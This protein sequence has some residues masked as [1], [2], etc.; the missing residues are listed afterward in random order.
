MD[1]KTIAPEA[2]SGVGSQAGERSSGGVTFHG[3]T[4]VHG[5]MAGR[6]IIKDNIFNVHVEE[7]HGDKVE[8]DKF[9][10]HLGDVGPG[11]Q[12]AIGK[13]IS[14]TITQT[15]I[16]LTTAER[17]E[18][19]HLLAELKNQLARLE[20]P[21]NKKVIGQELVGQ[22]EKELTKTEEPP[23]ASM[24]KIAGNWL[25]EN[26]PALAGTLATVFL[27]PVVGKI[28]EGAGDIAAEWVQEQLG[29]QA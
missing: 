1:E 24:I 21:E 5:D 19:E 2:D 9:E 3:D 6:D 4:K 22:L 27:N 7:V 25:L 13:D 29:T 18:L 10:G 20:I 14:Q 17:L 11:A 26:I 12:V 23:D 16:E 8:G 28:V 15:P